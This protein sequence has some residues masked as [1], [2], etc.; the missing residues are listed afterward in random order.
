M[1]VKIT[2]PEEDVLNQFNQIVKTFF[3]LMKK[4]DLESKILLDIRDTLLP[5]LMSG[6][7]RVPVEEDEQLV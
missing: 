3:A 2:I 5:R 6:E 7:I 1:S 4:N